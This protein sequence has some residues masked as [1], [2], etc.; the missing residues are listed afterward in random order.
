MYHQ[1]ND[2]E[3]TPSCS[4]Q[5]PQPLSRKI[6]AKPTRTIVVNTD[7]SNQLHQTPPPPPP[8]RTAPTDPKNRGKKQAMAFFDTMAQE[9]APKSR[10]LDIVHQMERCEKERSRRINNRDRIRRQITEL[11][12]K[13][14][15][16]ETHIAEIE[17]R[18][19]ELKKEDV[20]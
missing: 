16:E 5:R 15:E 8:S 11:K 7:S 18:V 9:R 3:H 17:D 19:R 12:D 13:L 14:V 6:P 1:S 2:D 20:E 4:N 10:R